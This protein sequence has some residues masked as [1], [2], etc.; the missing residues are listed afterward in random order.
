MLLLCLVLVN[1]FKTSFSDPGILPRATTLEAIEIDRQN[2]AGHHP[3]QN[4]QPFFKIYKK[5]GFTVMSGRF[6]MY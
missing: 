2:V 4:L 6:S 5:K 3:L 1:L